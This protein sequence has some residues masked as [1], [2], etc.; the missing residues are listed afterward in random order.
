MLAKPLSAESSAPAIPQSLIAAVEEP[1]APASRLTCRPTLGIGGRIAA[2]LDVC[3]SAS[4]C[5]VNIEWPDRREDV[6]KALDVLASI[7][8]ALGASGSDPRWPDMTNAVHWLVDD[9]GWDHGDSVEQ[10]IGTILRDKR[11]AVVVQRAVA[12]VMACRN[13]KVRAAAMRR[14]STTR[15]GLRSA[16][17]HAQRLPSSAHPGHRPDIGMGG[18]GLNVPVRGRS[19][20]S[21]VWMSM[22]RRSP[23]G[24]SS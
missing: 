22:I 3:G 18:R 21:L 11:E 17:R 14:G 23:G 19:D 2:D 1:A 9:T 6:L 16:R 12:A 5:P 13:A 24:L 4:M 8:P 15:V 7:P 20:L 10:S